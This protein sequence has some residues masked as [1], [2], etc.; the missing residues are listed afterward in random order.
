M[1]KVEF[2]IPDYVI[3][4]NSMAPIEAKAKWP[5]FSRRHFQVHFHE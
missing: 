4:N 5:P 2:E 1:F 3:R